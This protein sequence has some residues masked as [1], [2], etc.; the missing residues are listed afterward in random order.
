MTFVTM[1]YQGKSYVRNLFIVYLSKFCLQYQQAVL[2]PFYYNVPWGKVISQN[3][4]LTY[5][6]RCIYAGYTL[7]GSHGRNPMVNWILIKD[8]PKLWHI[9]NVIANLLPFLHFI[10]CICST[11]LVSYWGRICFLSKNVQITVF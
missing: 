1:F 5:D 7:S 4:S 10:T 6:P 9:L 11:F 3:V 8:S 2:I